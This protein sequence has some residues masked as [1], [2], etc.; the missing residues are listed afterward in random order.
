M[1]RILIICLTALT[2]ML[3]SSCR[4]WS[5][6]GDLDGF[7]Q[8]QEITYTQ[9]GVKVKAGQTVTMP[10]RYISINLELMQLQYNGSSIVAT[11]VIN[12]DRKGGVLTVDWPYNP[13]PSLLQDFGIFENPVRFDVEKVDSKRLVLRSPGAIVTCRRW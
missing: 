3:G 12:Y 5:H 8:I 4:R 9:D 6:H 10:E 7:W 11:G 13:K 2:L 1:T